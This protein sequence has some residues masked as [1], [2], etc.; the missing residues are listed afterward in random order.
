[1]FRALAFIPTLVFGI[2]WLVKSR[3]FFLKVGNERVFINN[4]KEVFGKELFPKKG[5]FIRRTINS[6]T[7]VLII[8]AIFCVDIAM[9]SVGL[10][11]DSAAEINLLPDVV[12]ALLIFSSTIMLERYIENT[13]RTK[14]SSL[15][16][17]FFSIIASVLKILFV[18]K[19]DYYTAINK[20]DAAYGM[21]N[22]MCLFTVLENLAF[23]ATIV[24]LTMTLREVI[25]K[26]TGYSAYADLQSSERITSLQNEL[27]GKLVYMIIFAV[28]SAISA[29]MYEILLP[30]KHLLAQYMWVIDFVVQALFA[31][32]TLRCLFAI[33]DEMENK[34][35][36]E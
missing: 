1:M 4:I 7:S 15:V 20:V 5:I 2:F 18:A 24:F 21:F 19:F 27:T 33:K 25:K 30:E 3:S 34:F 10:V 23:V 32:F 11:G 17:M 29:T 8:A 26:Y 36:L 14:I 9:G 6:V 13:K 16:F 28:L 12:A 22:I 31:I 35:M